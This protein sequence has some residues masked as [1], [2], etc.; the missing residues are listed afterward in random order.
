M[1]KERSES[2]EAKV[3]GEKG[4]SK[5]Q[6]G[7]GKRSEGNKPMKGEGIKKKKKRRLCRGVYYEVRPDMEEVEG[8]DKQGGESYGWGK[9]ERRQVI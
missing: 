9:E 8:E 5:G 2:G 3:T 4:N 7:R 6:R 1:R